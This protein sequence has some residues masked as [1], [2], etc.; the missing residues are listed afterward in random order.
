MIEIKIG[1]NNFITTV[2]A[3]DPLRPLYNPESSWEYRN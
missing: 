2:L 3:D 1:E